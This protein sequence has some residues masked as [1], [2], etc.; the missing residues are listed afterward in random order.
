MRSYLSDDEDEPKRETTSTSTSR[1]VRQ[2]RSWLDWKEDGKRAYEKGDYIHALESYRQAL[3]PEYECPTKADQAVLW[4]NVVACR[5]QLVENSRSTNDTT[6]TTSTNDDGSTGGRGRGDPQARAAVEDA[7]QCVTL[8]PNWAKGYLRLASAYIALGGHSNDACNALQST[9]RL[10]PGNPN[11]RQ[12]LVRELRRDHAAAF[13]ASAS[14]VE[15]DDN[16][17][18][19]NNI[20]N[21]DDDLRDPPMNPNFTP[22]PTTSSFSN[23]NSYAQSSASASFSAFAPPSSAPTPPSPPD[24]SVDDG[25]TWRERVTFTTGRWWDWYQNLSADTKTMI[26]IGLVI[27][28]LYVAFGGRFGLLSLSS[29]PSSS[30]SSRESRYHSSSSNGGEGTTTGTR[31]SR[32]NYGSDNAYEQYRR[33]RQQQRQ[34]Q[35][36]Y[37]HDRRST[38]YQQQQQRYY[39]SYYDDA[40]YAPPRYTRRNN[41]RR[42]MFSLSTLFDGSPQSL[43]LLAGIAYLCY[44]SGIN[45]FQA[46]VMLILFARGGRRRHGYGGGGFGH[47]R[48]GYR[49][50]FRW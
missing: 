25:L 9:L 31:T 10:D 23:S 32:G 2:M 3:R 6:T 7:K 15:N 49:R 35:Q 44:R 22:P 13:A 46:I 17:I 5:L 37:A 33:Q 18:N 40:Y 36:H 12:M 50:G 38:S 24:S 45:P 19:N 42:S 27:V 4:S 21:N 39:D 48:Y 34:E 8:N 29:S 47:G 11:A 43:L 20:N 28:F 1:S 26:K 16:S 41:T 30:S 14:T